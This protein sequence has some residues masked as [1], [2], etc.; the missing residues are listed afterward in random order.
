MGLTRASAPNRLPWDVKLCGAAWVAHRAVKSWLPQLAQHAP[1][2]CNAYANA[3]VRLHREVPVEVALKAARTRIET[4]MAPVHAWARS[5][6]D[7][8]QEAPTPMVD[9]TAHRVATVALTPMA[10]TALT[11]LVAHILMQPVCPF[12]MV[13][14]A[15]MTFNLAT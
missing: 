11:V 12:V 2:C 7:V 10:A 14:V 3:K 6:E 13:K 9:A 1:K 15:M 8:V 4:L 5:R